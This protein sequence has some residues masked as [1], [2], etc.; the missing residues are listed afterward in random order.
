[1]V[2]ADGQ[3]QAVGL[4]LSTGLSWEHMQPRLGLAPEG[5]HTEAKGKERRLGKGTSSG[6]VCPG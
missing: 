4:T 3:A 5:G 1:M 6:P 2:I